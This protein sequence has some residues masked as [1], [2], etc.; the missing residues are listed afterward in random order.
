MK[1]LLKSDSRVFP[2][3]TREKKERGSLV[4]RMFRHG[5]TDIQRR[6]AFAM[7]SDRFIP[8]YLTVKIHE[9]TENRDEIPT[10]KQQISDKEFK[11][12]SSVGA[13]KEKKQP[14]NE[15]EEITHVY[16]SG[17]SYVQPF[18]NTKPRQ[19]DLSDN[20]TPKGLLPP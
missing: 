15:I 5:R 2:N 19:D 1:S 4:E 20:E 12:L 8:V 3:E 10:L 16:D 7:C 9:T 17:E 18:N 13:M 14:T 11:V 6:L